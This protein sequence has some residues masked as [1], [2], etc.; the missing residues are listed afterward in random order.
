[1]W[2]FVAGGVALLVGTL[3]VVMANRDLAERFASEMR[4]ERERVK[5]ALVV[6]QDSDIVVLPEPVQRYLKVTGNVGKARP[7]S[8]LITFDATL[9]DRGNTAGMRGTAFQYDAFDKPKR[10][11][12]ME[13]RMNGMPVKVLHDYDGIAATMV[14]RLLSLIDVVDIGGTEISRTETVTLLNDLALFAPSWLADPRLAWTPVDQH[15]AKVRFTN[16]SH[17]VA[18]QL[19]FNDAGELVDFISDDRGALNK[20]GSLEYVRW[21]TP[22]HGYHDVDG[23]RL[24]RGGDAVQR[25]PEGAFTYGKFRVRKIEYGY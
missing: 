24:P 17:S 8:V 2:R 10:L 23:R 7:S 19:F 25:F 18:A 20:D 12:F 11:F 6:L 14:V 5:P 4:A 9:F 22:V 16:G 3:Y 1:M 13:T 21:S 15:S